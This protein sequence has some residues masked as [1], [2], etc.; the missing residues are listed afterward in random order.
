MKS[1]P[2]FSIEYV[3]LLLSTLGIKRSRL[4]HISLFIFPTSNSEE[5]THKAGYVTFDNHIIALDHMG[6]IYIRFEVLDRNWQLKMFQYL[7]LCF[8]YYPILNI[9]NISLALKRY[10]E[11][12]FLSY[13][14]QLVD[15]RNVP[16]G[17]Q[18]LQ[19]YLQCSRLILQTLH[20]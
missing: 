8:Y 2:F 18:P 4:I 12:Y 19:S 10:F 20:P 14:T 1:C 11:L 7:L 17:Q 13:N 6:L 3:R 9:F 15:K 16:S 5:V